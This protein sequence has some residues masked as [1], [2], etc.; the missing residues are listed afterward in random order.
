MAVLYHIGVGAARV[1]F[2]AFGRFEVHGAEAVPPRG[3]LIVVANHMSNADPPVVVAAVPRR[4]FIM[5]KRGLFANRLITKIFNDIGVYPLDRDGKDTAALRWALRLLERDGA[6]LLFPEGTRSKD[7]QLHKALTGVAYVALRSQAPVLPVAI[8]GTERIPG[9][10]RIAMPLC[11][12][13]VWIG[14]P[15][16]LPN[17]EGR[18]SRELLE[19][20]TDMMMYRIAAMLPEQYRGYYAHQGAASTPEGGAKHDSEAR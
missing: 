8:A 4:L 7:A 10:L 15:F 14:Q 5:A 3:P 16:T 18:V 1:A 11:R 17:L 9:F 20:L 12:I 13:R 2:R 19:S 6:L